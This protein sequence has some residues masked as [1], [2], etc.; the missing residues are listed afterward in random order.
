MYMDVSYTT[1]FQTVLRMP[2]TQCL[3]HHM[4]EH[5]LYTQHEGMQANPNIVWIAPRLTEIFSV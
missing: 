4:Y 2:T 3:V 1:C 5:V